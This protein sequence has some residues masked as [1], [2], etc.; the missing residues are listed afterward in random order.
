[1]GTPL[2]RQCHKSYKLIENL[3]E[4]ALSAHGPRGTINLLFSRG[5]SLFANCRLFGTTS[6][7][8]DIRGEDSVTKCL[9]AA[10]IYGD[11]HE[12]VKRSTYCGEMVR[13]ASSGQDAMII[14]VHKNV[15]VSYKL[16]NTKA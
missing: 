10:V 6:G 2:V 8:W 9:Y 14:S 5:N 11:E 1:M 12:K 7:S 4:R 3:D 15:L 16:S 13:T